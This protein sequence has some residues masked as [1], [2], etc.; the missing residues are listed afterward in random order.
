MKGLYKILPPFAPDY[1]GVCAVLFELGGLV[2]VYDA[3][4]CAFNVTNYDEPRWYGSSAAILSASL[5]EIEAVIGDDEKL[6]KK[7]EDSVRIL[8]R[9]FVAILGSPASMVIGTD[10]QAL[11]D[12]ISKRTGLPALA[13][14]T[15]GLKYYD[16]GA[17]MAFEALARRCINP[18]CSAA[19]KLVNIIG[20]TP[21]DIGNQRN[22]QNLVEKLVEAGC[23]EVLCWG[24]GT[25]LQE[26]EEKAAQAHLN[27]VVSNAGLM[28]ARYMQQMYKIPFLAGIPIGHAPSLRFIAEVR[29]L[30]GLMER[31]YTIE[32]LPASSRNALVIGEQVMGN[33]I[34]TC[35]GMDFGINQVTV[36]SF[37]SM[38]DALTEAGDIFLEDE[39]DLTALAN[40]H[41]YNYIIGDP[42][43]KK[44]LSSA[45]NCFIDFPHIAVSSH[46]Y[47]DN[48][49][50]YVGDG[51][52]DFFKQII[53]TGN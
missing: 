50:E 27:I 29:S 33:S 13:F 22:M 9:S 11:A 21:L 38:D 40:K 6:L 48:D 43:Y 42:L 37:F 14:N 3:G 39:D 41:R 19:N 10:Y 2:V 1:S 45:G 15:N 17:A 44:I 35:L 30:L 8:R 49:I 34:R 18:V 32:S 52:V 7:I 53:N 20:A 16:Q 31:S 47:W 28:A 4:G 51:G 24:M 25:T 12:I 23:K 5:R 26:I 46:L 36:A